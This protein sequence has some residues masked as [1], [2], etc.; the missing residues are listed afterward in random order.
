[1][2]NF[3][4]ESQYFG[5]STIDE[6]DCELM[7]CVDRDVPNEVMVHY[8]TREITE[9]VL[10]EFVD[11]S[12]DDATLRPKQWFTPSQIGSIQI[13]QFDEAT[14][15]RLAGYSVRLRRTGAGYVGELLHESGKSAPITIDAPM[16][17]RVNA[18]PCNTWQDLKKWADKVRGSGHVYRGHGQSQFKLKSSFHRTERA[19]IERFIAD[20]VPRFH[21]HAEA[22]LRT[23]INL[24]DAR[25]MAMLMGL[26]QHHGLPTPLLD[27]TESPYVA[28]FFAFT[29]AIAN[30]SSGATHVRIYSLA[31][32]FLSRWNTPN[33]TLD[34]VVPYVV[35]FRVSPY[36]NDRIYAQRGLFLVSN[37][38]DLESYVLSVDMSALQAVDIP[39]TCA[40]DA[41]D[42]LAHM[43]ITHASLFPGLDGVCRTLAYEMRRP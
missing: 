23:R 33:V 19:R 34:F 39:I 18:T 36:L 10:L 30:K 11:A 6:Q 37:V 4:A 41:L 25:D 21:S 26:A 28:A 16:N 20:V 38:V 42:D 35:P 2:G 32:A 24:Q 15:K 1:M 31:S 27:W 12:L 13:A 5:R 17:L 7:L 8:W 3:F 29:D 40:D 43:G 14:R 9:A 22:V